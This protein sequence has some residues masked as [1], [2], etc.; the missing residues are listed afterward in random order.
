MQGYSFQISA[1]TEYEI[2][3]GATPI[4]LDY[5]NNLLQKIQVLTVDQSVVKTAVEINQF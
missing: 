3:S 4:Q 5:C 1:I 2:Y